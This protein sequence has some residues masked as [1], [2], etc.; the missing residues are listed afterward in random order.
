MDKDRAFREVQENIGKKRYDIVGPQVMLIA[1]EYSD[2]PI[3]LLTCAS[4]LK[5]VED[6]DRVM[7][8]VGMISACSDDVSKPRLE[9]AK[10]LKGLGFPAESDAILRK[11]SVTDV[12]LRER[13]NA[14]HMM[15]R[16]PE[17]V[18]VHDDMEVPTITDDVEYVDILLSMKENTKA[19]E[20]ATS[21]LGEEPDDYDVL[22]CYC[23]ALLRSG[24]QKEAE[25]FVKDYLKKD[26]NSATGNA[27]AAFFMWMTGKTSAAGGFATKAVKTDSKHIGGMEILA[28]CLIEKKKIPEAKIVA[29]AI[30]E[31][32]P[33]HPAV[34]RILNMCKQ[35]I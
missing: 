21:I 18:E 20:T 4:L 30:N 24:Q 23:S 13:M 15:C 2:D 29:G 11:L 32:N 25:R 33:G 5:V 31:T 10:G 16:Y 7:D 3:T 1:S 34:I 26:K 14:L 35:K 12:V 28:I 27:L 9:I 22:R 6:D 19:I 8:I 17:A